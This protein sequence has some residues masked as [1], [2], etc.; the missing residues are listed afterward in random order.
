MTKRYLRT[1]K[2]KPVYGTDNLSSLI[3]KDSFLSLVWNY[4][5]YWMMPTLVYEEDFPREKMN[6]LS[7][8]GYF[9]EALLA[10][11]VMYLISKLTLIVLILIK[12]VQKNMMPIIEQVR[13]KVKLTEM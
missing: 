11:V 9:G 6:I 4:V 7:A 1:T 10:V 3:L 13:H 8:L 12:L 5:D 2:K